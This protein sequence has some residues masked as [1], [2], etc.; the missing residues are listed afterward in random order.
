MLSR[1]LP[2]FMCIHR[3]HG[4]KMRPSITFCT[5]N[6]QVQPAETKEAGSQVL[7]KQNPKQDRPKK[8][9]PRLGSGKTGRSL[10]FCAWSCTLSTSE[11]SP[12]HKMLR[13][14][15]CPLSASTRLP[16][17]LEQVS[18]EHSLQSTDSTHSVPEASR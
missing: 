3:L 8:G 4:G 11:R 9:R 16:Q 18:R 1:Q 5:D 2:P 13:Q 14:H 7:R 17:T 6:Q 12:G 10:R 15:S